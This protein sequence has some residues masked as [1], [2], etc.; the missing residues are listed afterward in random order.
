MQGQFVLGLIVGVLIYLGLTILGVQYSLLLAILAAIFE[1]IPFGLILAAIPAIVLAFLQD[2]TLGFWVIVF[3]VVVQQ[4][5]NNI[6]VPIVMG[7]TIGLNPVVVILALLV[8][9]NLAGIAG[10]IIAVPVAT[11]IVEVLDD[12]AKKK[13]SRRLSS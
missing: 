3:Y 10:M 13:E 6:L 5:E 2:P 8:G 9:A 1:L 12:M 11:I 7:K 4:L